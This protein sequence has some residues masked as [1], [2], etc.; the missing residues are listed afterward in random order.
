MRAV[1]YERFQTPP[2]VRQ[3]DDPAC[4]ADGVILAVKACGICRS[5]WHGWMGNDPDIRLPHVPGHELAGEIVALGSEISNSRS[6]ISNFKIGNR[7]TLPFV[8]GCGKCEPCLSGNQQVCDNQFQPGFT[9][10][11]GFAEFVAIKYADSNLVLLPDEIDFVTAASLGCRFATSFRAVV[12]QGKVSPGQW[13]AVWGCGGVGL[14]AIMIAAAFGAR[15]IG[16]DIANDKLEFARSVGAE[17]VINSGYGNP[18]AAIMDITEGGAHISIDALGHPEILFNS[19]AS[20]RKRGKHIQVGIMES[21]KHS[22]PIP[23]DKVIG[24]ELEIL[25]SHGMQAHRYPEMLEMIRQGRLN[26][27]K[28]IG[29]SVSLEDAPSEL[30]NMD[31]FS[32]TGVIVIE[33]AD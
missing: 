23:I 29:K 15:V 3:T 28:L 6:Q 16:I 26:P 33:I 7:V 1:V 32:G 8:C 9:A 14:S 24:R 27:Q 18:T 11:G 5:D 30:I 21:G 4:D 25:G 13:V 2:D 19:V 20:L 22:P 10:W 17:T 31:Q 12:D